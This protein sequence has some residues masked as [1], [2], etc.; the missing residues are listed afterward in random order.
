M[1]A[2]ESDTASMHYTKLNVTSNRT[3]GVCQSFAFRPDNPI[4]GNGTASAL[5][6]HTLTRPGRRLTEGSAGEVCAVLELVT[7]GDA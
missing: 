5:D 1:L 7:W 2:F 4:A 3:L 6:A